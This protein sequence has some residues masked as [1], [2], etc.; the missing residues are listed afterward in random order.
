MKVLVTAT[1]YSRYC[2]PGK[3]ILEEAGCEIIENPHGRPYTTEELKA[4]VGDVDG[5]IAGVDTWNEEIFQLAPRLKV[6]ARFGVGVDNFD[7]EAAKKHGITVCNCPGINSSAVAEQAMALMLALLRRVPE[8][9]KSIRSGEWTRPMFHEMKSRTVGFLGFGAIA[10]STAEKLGG[11]HPSM[12]AYDKYPNVEAAEKL[13]VKIATLD[14]VLAESD[15][16]SIHLPAAEDT[17]H[18]IGE[19]NI[20][21]MK[22]GVLIVNTARG[23]IVD[24]KAV[25]DAM[26]SGKIGGL[27][28]DVFE[29]EPV[30][31]QNPL[32]GFDN[33]I[34]GPHIAAETYENCEETSIMTAESV[35]K[36]FRGEAPHNRMICG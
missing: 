6:L 24:E 22:D 4:I 2:R 35:L 18:L 10:R 36:V 13:G 14:R 1:N 31:L 8:L 11:F 12:L 33:Y 29:S 15:I 9:N 26:K 30:D 27:A 21:K 16:L 32:F 7:L 5:V 28:T 34:A 19:E 20:K 23:S 25:A 17:F 3:Q